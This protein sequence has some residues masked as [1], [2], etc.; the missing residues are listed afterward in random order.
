MSFGS[1]RGHAY[2]CRTQAGNKKTPFG[3]YPLKLM[4]KTAA[5]AHPM[6]ITMVQYGYRVVRPHGRKKEPASHAQGVLAT[7]LTHSTAEFEVWEWSRIPIA[8]AAA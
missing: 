1:G 8:N 7:S 5:S 4:E 2:I 6:S 3:Q